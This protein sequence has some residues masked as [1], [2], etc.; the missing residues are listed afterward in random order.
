MTDIKPDADAGKKL[1]S[2]LGGKEIDI[3]SDHLREAARVFQSRAEQISTVKAKMEA[4]ASSAD[5]ESGRFISEHSPKEVYHTAV[6]SLKAIATKFGGEM[7]K[8]VT[9]MQTKASALMWIAENHD[10][11]E[12][13]SAK[14]MQKIPD[15]VAPGTGAASPSQPVY[16]I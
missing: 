16:S 12:D 15:Q 1:R 10:T 9:A 3:D 13:E 6:G 2:R 5:S 4:I 8:A 7:D 11:T 14:N